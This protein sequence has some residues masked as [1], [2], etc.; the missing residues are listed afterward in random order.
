MES[1][2]EDGAGRQAVPPPP[3]YAPPPPPPPIQRHP[4]RNA[5]SSDRSW[6]YYS[7]SPSSVA[8]QFLKS[9]FGPVDEEGGDAA[10]AAAKAANATDDNNDGGGG[11]DDEVK[12]SSRVSSK[13]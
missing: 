13:R 4:S 1:G 5:S 2:S 9:L 10:N 11:D 12:P 6:E 7:D 3:Q 8:I